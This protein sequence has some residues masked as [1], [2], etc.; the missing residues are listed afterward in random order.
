MAWVL[1]QGAAVFLLGLMQPA[2]LVEADGGGKGLIENGVLHPTLFQ[3]GALPH[4]GKAGPP[5]QV[6]VL[7]RTYGTHTTAFRVY[8]ARR[9]ARRD[10]G[11]SQA[12]RNDD[13]WARKAAQRVAFPAPSV[14]QEG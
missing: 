10:A 5:A 1:A 11:A 14:C 12:S 4:N 13:R 7:D 6:S 3:D 2:C 8:P 9:E